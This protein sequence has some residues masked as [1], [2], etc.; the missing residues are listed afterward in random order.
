MKDTRLPLLLSVP[1]ASL[2]VPVE[3]RTQHVL[4]QAQ[5]AAD[6]DV[7]AAAIY[8]LSEQVRG[9]VAAPVAR[10]FVDMNRA[11]D[12]LRKDGVVKTHT[13]WDEPIYRQPLSPTLVDRLLRRYHRP[14]H[15]ELS[16]RAESEVVL[17][18]D[19]HTM[20]AEGPPVSP[21][22]G[23]VRP[24][25]CLSDCDGKTCPTNWLQ[26]LRRCFAAEFDDDVRLNDPFHGGYITRSHGAEMPWVQLE[27]SRAPYCSDVDKQAR[28]L[29]ALEAWT[30]WYRDTQHSS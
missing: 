9:Y 24:K 29:R 2:Q 13:C 18:I 19:C 20:A 6:G 11:E 28:V 22:P 10:A 3:L 17:A 1:H 21:G 4:T 16:A 5:I 12:D 23:R 7:G 27:L 26:A 14:Y 8:A 25:V 30:A 15:D